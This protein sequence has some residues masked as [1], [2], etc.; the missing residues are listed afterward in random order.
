VVE[1]LE[2]GL[3]PDPAGTLEEQLAEQLDDG[4]GEG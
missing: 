4:P 2:S 1:Q 3:R